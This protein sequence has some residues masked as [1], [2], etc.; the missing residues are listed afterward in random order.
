MK[1]CE[2]GC[3]KP[4]P[5][6]K[7]SMPYRGY[8]KGQPQRFLLGHNSS[9]G[10]LS[11][12]FWASTQVVLRSKTVGRG[13]NFFVNTHGIGQDI[14]IVFTLDPTSYNV[15][16]QPDFTGVRITIPASSGS[17]DVYVGRLAAASNAAWYSYVTFHYV[18]GSCN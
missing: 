9:T 5:I 16:G 11:K 13:G 14:C 4:T 12:R 15:V 8:K 10:P 18:S 1:L 6:T 3:G 17:N 2:C 7:V